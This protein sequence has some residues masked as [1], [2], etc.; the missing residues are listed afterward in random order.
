MRPSEREVDFHDSKRRKIKTYVSEHTCQ[1]KRG[2]KKLTSKYLI[3]RF[4]GFILTHPDITIRYLKPFMEKSL[5]LEQFSLLADWQNEAG[6]IP[7]KAFYICFRGCKEGMLN[8]CRPILG[9]DGCFLKGLVKGE[10]LT[11]IGHDGNNQMFPLA[12][13]M[14]L[15]EDTETWTW[16]LNLLRHDLRTVEGERWTLISDRQKGLV[17][18][19]ARR[20]LKQLFWKLAKSTNIPNFELKLKEIE[21]VHAAVG[22]DLMLV[23]PKYWSK[24]ISIHG[25]NVIHVT[26]I[27]VKLSMEYGPLIQKK[28]INNV[29]ES[30]FWVSEWNGGRSY[31]VKNGR[32]QFVVKLRDGTCA[33][34]AWQ[35]SGI[36][37]PHAIC[38]IHTNG[39][40]PKNYLALWYRKRHT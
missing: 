27:F 37:C 21:K 2:L 4:Y 7:F 13:A 16:F 20:H 6:P 18:A 38:A 12:W 39:E 35:I 29:T 19:V 28:L 32:S 25:L 1:P 15:V 31:E 9:N 3:D 14:M 8:G 10:L 22:K 30:H 26:I 36:P 33:C 17:S 34:G 11:T 5:A 23:H 40:K 24:L